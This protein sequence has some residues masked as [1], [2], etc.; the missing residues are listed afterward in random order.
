MRSSLLQAVTL[1]C[2]LLSIILAG[3]GNSQQETKKG[4]AKPTKA[5]RATAGAGPTGERIKRMKGKPVA[6]KISALMSFKQ[7][8]VYDIQVPSALKYFNASNGRNP[9]N[10]DEFK[11]EI[12]EENQ[13]VLPKLPDDAKYEYRPKD[14][15]FGQ[16]WIVPK[17]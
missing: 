7:K 12:I 13:I 3:C 4:E 5:T 9:R 17:S 11:R 15:Q 2:V 16:L 1:N 6:T 14:G 8:A 10:F